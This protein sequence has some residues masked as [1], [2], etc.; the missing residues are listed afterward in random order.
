MAEDI[1]VIIREIQPVDCRALARFLEDNNIP[2]VTRHF[3]PFPLTSDTAYQIA[4]TTHLDR[5]YIVLLGNRIV[6]LCMLRGWD[7]GFEIPSFGILVDRRFHGRGLGRQIAEFAI[8]VAQRSGCNRMRLSVYATNAP[9]LH[10]YASLGFQEA[11]REVVMVD[12][13][14]DEKII[15]YKDL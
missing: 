6:G 12:G 10:L 7:E 5:Y 13:E 4:C 14:R 2:E 11:D 1:R 8:K 9:A 3:R 15:M